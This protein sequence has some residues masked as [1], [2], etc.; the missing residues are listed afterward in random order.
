[1]ENKQR[2]QDWINLILGAWLFLSPFFGFGAFKDAAS[3][4]S[5]IFGAIVFAIS[6]I[7]LLTPQLWEE[8]I[9]GIIGLWLIASPFILAFSSHQLATWNDIIV[10]ILILGDAIWAGAVQPP[11]QPLEHAH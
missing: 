1:M 9:N 3:W 7:A 6:A 11:H 5:Y 4:N 8:W 10:G 2:W